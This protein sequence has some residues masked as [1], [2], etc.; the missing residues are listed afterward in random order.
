M[1][2]ARALYGGDSIAAVA[3]VMAGL[4]M[5]DGLGMGGTRERPSFALWACNLKTFALFRAMLTQ[6]RVGMAGLTGLDYT[7]LP[8]CARL[9]GIK[10]TRARFAEIQA[11]EGAVLALRDEKA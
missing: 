1:A 10:L 5:P 8:V 2:A 9:Q 6:W 11:M 4:D 3:E 7:A